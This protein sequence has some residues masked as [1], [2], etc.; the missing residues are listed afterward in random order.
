MRKL[1]HYIMW[2]GQHSGV[3][4]TPRNIRPF[5]Y[6]SFNPKKTAILVA[7]K[8]GGGGGGAYRAPP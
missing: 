7:G 1:D 2:S 6:T 4:S 8:T 5:Q 3:Y